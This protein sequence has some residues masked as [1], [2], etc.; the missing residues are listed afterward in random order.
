MVVG[1]K[2][3]DAVANIITWRKTGELNV[4]SMFACAIG[5]Y[6]YIY[7]KFNDKYR[8]VNLAGSAAGLR[9]QVSYNRASWLRASQLI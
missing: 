9:C 7:D 1:K 3:T 6:A 8:W 4:N 2:A 5:N